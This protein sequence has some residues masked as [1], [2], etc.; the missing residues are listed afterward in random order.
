VEVAQGLYVVIE[1]L[2]VARKTGLKTLTT[3]CILLGPLLGF[4]TD[5]VVTAAGT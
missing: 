3:W 1:L 2:D 5:A 4:A